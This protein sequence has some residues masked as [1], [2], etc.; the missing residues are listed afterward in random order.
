MRHLL[1][2]EAHGWVAQEMWAVVDALAFIYDKN[3]DEIE[4][5]FRKEV[6]YTGLK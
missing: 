1:R 4:A 2:K 3:S 5:E 6:D